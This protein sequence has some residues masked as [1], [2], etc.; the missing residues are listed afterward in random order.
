MAYNKQDGKKAFL[1]RLRSAAIAF[2]MLSLLVPRLFGGAAAYASDSGGSQD[3]G[4]DNVNESG[5]IYIDYTVYAGNS[6]RV[7]SEIFSGD[8]FT[9]EARFRI[10]ESIGISGDIN[11]QT[12]GGGFTGGVGAVR[13]DEG[14]SLVTVVF[15]LVY[16]GS[17]STT[18]MFN[19]SGKR[20][21]GGGEALNFNDPRNVT[22]RE[23]RPDSEG[24]D[25]IAPSGPSEP[26][27]F[28]VD[29]S[30]RFPVANAGQAYILEIP[31]KNVGKQAAR[32]IV[33][34]IDP[35]EAKD[36]PFEY[37]KY[38]FT[39]R[40]GELAANSVRDARFELRVLPA[41]GSGQH[42]I[43]VDFSGRAVLGVGSQAESS[44][45]IVITVNN[46]NTEP[47]LVLEGISLSKDAGDGGGGNGGDGG[48]DGGELAEEV[49]SVIERVPDAP[50]PIAAV[51]PGTD[52]YLSLRISN[53][54]TLPA[55]NAALTLKG[56]KADGISTNNA[57]DVQYMDSIDGMSEI[58]LLFELTC[59]E[60]MAGERTELILSMAYADETGKAYSGESQVFIPLVQVKKEASFTSFEFTDVSAPAGELGEGSNF[61]IS[62]NVL[63]TG[64][65]PMEDVKLTYSAGSEF[66]GKSLNTRM[67]KPIAPGA[68]VPLTFEF[69]VSKNYSTGNF[70]ISF[71]I[72][73]TPGEAE[74]G[75]A[76]AGAGDDGG[77]ENGS[78]DSGG[79]G[80]G[81]GGGA[82]G[83]TGG[84]ANSGGSNSRGERISATQYVGILLFKPEETTTTTTTTTTSSDEKESVPKIIISNYEYSPKEAMA[85]HAV[86]ITL[87][88]F[89][90]SMSQA[91]K[92]IKIQL[93]S[94]I[95]SSSGYNSASSG[96]F[97]PIEG[98]NSFY[99]ETIAPR[100]EVERSIKLMIKGD[101]DEKSYQL[102]SNIEYEDSKSNPITAKESISIP[103][104][105]ITRVTI[106]DIVVANPVISPNQPFNVSYT[107]INM[108]KTT[109]YNVMAYIEGPSSSLSQG[110]YAGNL[111]PG[112]QDYYDANITAETA[113][114]QVAYA[115]ITYEDSQ[116]NPRE[117]RAEFP[118]FVAEMGEMGDFMYDGDRMGYPGMDEDMYGEIGGGGIM[119]YAMLALERLRDP[120]IAIAA[121]AGV[122]VIIIVIVSLVRRAKHKKLER[123]LNR[124]A[125]KELSEDF[126]NGKN[127]GRKYGDDR[128]GAGGGGGAYGAGGGSYGVGSGSYGADKPASSQGGGAGGD[129]YNPRGADGNN[130]EGGNYPAGGN[131]PAGGNAQDDSIS[132]LMTAIEDRD[133]H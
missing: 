32:D 35:G 120:R 99:I 4:G 65:V 41:A 64:D 7:L 82:N 9:L 13:V 103:V 116:G 80:G 118:F 44:E 61:N 43:K 77:G 87:T 102:Y 114:E 27:R 38:A 91:V 97:T 52:F 126:Y 125:E 45:T 39:A 24:A 57:P 96:V 34:S 63:N 112:S 121:G 101:A 76:G 93:D 2:M 26:P 62:F 104:S 71:T 3:G 129:S 11:V 72:E 85:G 36:F 16:T 94:D 108:G 28:A 37:D 33:I 12:T 123:E 68:S 6:N 56:L 84:G 128:G 69:S 42:S 105:Q 18:L 47:K 89:N 86:D 1:S 46:T 60:G 78:G 90:T 92:N 132:S 70:P 29:I 23:C 30:A 66:I 5:L 67:L 53:S 83:G 17:R 127:S 49:F 111:A 124:I 81:S 106:G 59:A 107:F 110:Y 8:P 10:P 51:T 75:G 133:Q 22:I 74:S 14:Q 131:N 73:Y 31:V 130:P 40:I 55:K 19:L 122:L 98:S 100:E 113:G 50:V 109:L 21:I 54:G 48:S 95:E 115:L 119:D 79:G 88:F 15:N 20:S 25:A 117:E 58:T